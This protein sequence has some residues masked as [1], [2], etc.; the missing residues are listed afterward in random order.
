MSSRMMSRRSSSPIAMYVAAVT[1]H[2]VPSALIYDT[3]GDES[4][5][6]ESLWPNLLLA[7]LFTLLLFTCNSFPLLLD[8][9]AQTMVYITGRNGWCDSG[10]ITRTTL[11]CLSRT[12]SLCTSLPEKDKTAYVELSMGMAAREG[13]R[14]GRFTRGT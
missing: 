12:S 11:R 14:N 6:D 9:D 4:R 10:G 1:R 7:I 5:I 13:L 8:H 2:S 3:G